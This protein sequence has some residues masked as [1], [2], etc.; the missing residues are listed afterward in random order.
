MM[1][2][3]S[4]AKYGR[5]LQVVCF[6]RRHR[7]RRTKSARGFGLLISQ[8][9]QAAR[10]ASLFG[11]LGKMLLVFFADDSPEA[12]LRRLRRGRIRAELFNV[13]RNGR[14]F[15]MFLRFNGPAA[16][17][18]GSIKTFGGGSSTPKPQPS[19]SAQIYS[20]RSVGVFKL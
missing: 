14:Y 11:L 16:S 6:R 5:T 2:M 19:I 4:M 9:V 20:F 10:A 3:V 8:I 18:D 15:W 13:V 7:S 17:R 12:M 1:R